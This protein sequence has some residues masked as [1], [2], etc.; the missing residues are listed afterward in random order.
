[1][2]RKHGKREQQQ[3]PYECR[4]SRQPHSCALVRFRTE[5]H[6]EI[7]DGS[8]GQCVQR[9]A[10][11]RHRCG[12]D[13]RNQQSGN[14][15]RHPAHDKRGIDPVRRPKTRRGYA[16]IHPKHHPHHQEES[17][18]K[19]NRHAAG[20]QRRHRLLLAPRRQQSLHDELIGAMTRRYE[21]RSSDHACPESV[22]VPETQRE[23]EYLQ[24][25]R[26]RGR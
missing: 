7:H 22:R 21:K 8:G 12:Q 26:A 13:C 3:S 1:M 4:K 17:K 18:L 2:Q 10:Q 11:V 24:L 20:E 15:V 16:V 19:E 14:S 9:R 5:A 25:A 6:I 23:V